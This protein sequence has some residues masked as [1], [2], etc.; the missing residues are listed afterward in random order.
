MANLISDNH[1]LARLTPDSLE[2]LSP[3]FDW[4]EFPVGPITALESMENIY[5]PVDG[6][7]SYVLS[8]GDGSS[9]EIA[10]AG[11]ESALGLCA[12]LN[13]TKPL[14]PLLAQRHITA[15]QLPVRVAVNEFQRGG[16]FQWLL[17]SYLRVFIRQIALASLCN[18]H[19]SLEQRFC[20]WLLFSQDTLG[21]EEPVAMSQ[22]MIAG[23]LGVRRE[24]ITRVATQ[25]RTRNLINYTTRRI[26]IVDRDGLE[27]NSCE[28][29]G[30]LR[31]ELDELL[32]EH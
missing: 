11:K 12:F 1:L 6:M 32:N 8:A 13:C 3:S 17:L 31:R 22:E 9:S 5:F 7:A 21:L 20:R 15:V 19:H 29:Y 14:V 10:L 27:N 30:H 4:V 23:M 24:A 28:C 26:E 18:A 2:R 16:R 25:L